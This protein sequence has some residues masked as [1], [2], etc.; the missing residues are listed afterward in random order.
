MNRVTKELRQCASRVHGLSLLVT[1]VVVAGI[2]C[3]VLYARTGQGDQAE[4]QLSEALRLHPESSSA[5]LALAGFYV[6]HGSLAS[7]EEVLDEALKQH[8]KL[9]EAH[10]QLALVLARQ[11]RYKEA[12]THIALV[13]PPVEPS[14]RVGYFRLVASIDSGLGDSRGAAH[15]IEEALQVTPADKQLQLIAA[16]AEAE[17]GEWTACM[18]NVA[19]LY[20][21][22]PSPRSGLILLQAELGSHTDFRPTLQ[23]LRALSLPA[24]QELELRTGTAELLASADQHLEAIAEL[25]QALRIAGPSDETLLYNLAVEQ[26]SARQFDKTFATLTSLRAQNDSA[27]IED[28]IGDVEEQNGDRAAAIHSHESAIALAPQEERFRLSLGAE[29]LKYQEYQA[30]VSVFQQAAELFPKSARIYVGLGMARYFMEKYDDSVAD[31]L[32]ADELDGGAGPALN[33][34]AATQV[35]NPAG[36]VPAAVDAICSRASS[37]KAGAAAVTW[38]S[39]LLFRKA[40]LTDNQAAAPE[41]IRRLRSSAKLMPGDPTATCTLGQALAWTEQLVEA[42]H[43]LEICV[44]LRPNSTEAHYR[45]SRVYL[46]LGM[47]QAAAE[48]AELIDSANAEHDQHQA[49]VNAFADEMLVPGDPKIGHK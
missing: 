25:Q 8:P 37:S 14:A 24:D 21:E 26:Y 27:E 30:A 1:F 36:P 28:L 10:L 45:L 44:R 49:M 18:R 22:H 9:T 13:P 12:Q 33:Y 20:Q 5:A 32:R 15:A 40:Y 19:P 23:S 16:V 6:A 35:D 3:R 43:W 29:L 41:I 17:A 2:T 34:L 47:K 48:Q 46:G 38:C 39:V 11:H 31:F 42:R 7:A 4:Q